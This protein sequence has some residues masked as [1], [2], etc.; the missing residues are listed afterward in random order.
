MTIKKRP[1]TRA[2]RG[3]LADKP[4][5]MRLMPAERQVLEQLAR[6]EHR[7]TSSMARRVFLAGVPAFQKQ[8]IESRAQSHS[9]VFAED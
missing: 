3:V 5:Y 4:V 9:K 8:G 1:I 2:P 6:Q 7:S